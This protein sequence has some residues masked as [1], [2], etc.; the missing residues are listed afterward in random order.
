VTTPGLPSNPIV[1]Q[2]A[3]VDGVFYMYVADLDSNGNVVDTVW[4]IANLRANGWT[5]NID[6]NNLVTLTP[7]TFLRNVISGGVSQKVSSTVLSGDVVQ[8]NYGVQRSESLA[9][10]NEAL[11]YGESV[12]SYTVLT[13]TLNTST[14]ITRFDGYGTRIINN[15]ISYE[16]PEVNDSW[17]K[18]PDNGPIL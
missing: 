6:S 13:T 1:G 18:F 7:T 8:I 12:P 2:V 16:D 15:R 9:L 17:L 5:I 11:T 10:Y 14:N 3:E 4:K